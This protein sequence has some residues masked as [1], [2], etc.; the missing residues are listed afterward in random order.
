MEKNI[1][2]NL[3]SPFIKGWVCGFVDGE[4]CFC[5]SFT[6]RKSMPCG[7]EVRPSFSISQKKHS[8]ESLQI[9]HKFFDCGGIRYSKGDGTYKYETRSIQDIKNKIL[10]FFEE[11][12]L[13]TKKKEDFTIFKNICKLILKGEHLNPYGLETIITQSYKLNGSGKRKH[14]INDLLKFISKLKV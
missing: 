10:P 1:D 9:I 6:I 14:E 3:T 8:L 13:F 4:G 11:N 5:V 7:I 2:V 12:N